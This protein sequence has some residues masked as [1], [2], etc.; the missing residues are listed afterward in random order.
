MEFP[1]PCWVL[2]L[3]EPS[4]CGRGAKLPGKTLKWKHDTPSFESG[5]AAQKCR[6]NTVFACPLNAT[7]LQVI[8]SHWKDLPFS[9]KSLSS[10]REEFQRIKTHTFLCAKEELWQWSGK[11]RKDP[12]ERASTSTTHPNKHFESWRVEVAKSHLD[13]LPCR[14]ML[15][16]D[17]PHNHPRSSWHTETPQ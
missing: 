9:G 8:G 13:I 11:V 3:S 5:L 17:A 7:L 12:A 14:K 2:C 10:I 16:G 15:P 6:T 1:I 4:N